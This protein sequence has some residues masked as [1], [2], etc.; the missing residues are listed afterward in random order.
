MSN[1]GSHA[2]TPTWKA[3]TPSRK[4]EDI[5][6]IRIVKVKSGDLNIRRYS[7]VTHLTKSKAEQGTPKSINHDGIP[8]TCVCCL[9]WEQNFMNLKREYK[10][11]CRVLMS[12]KV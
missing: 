5:H 9:A 12:T 10:R 6:G 11:L 3:G 8:D 2:S 4:V 1:G 7:H